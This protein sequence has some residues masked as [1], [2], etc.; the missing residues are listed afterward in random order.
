MQP[1]DHEPVEKEIDDVLKDEERRAVRKPNVPD[2]VKA[3]IDER[4]RRFD[5]TERERGD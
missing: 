2:D 4:L 5:E 1:R 3:E